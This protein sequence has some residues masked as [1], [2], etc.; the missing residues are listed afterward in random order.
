MKTPANVQSTAK[1]RGQRMI[2]SRFTPHARIAA[3]SLS[4]DMREKTRM[5]ATRSP[6]GIVHCIV[7]GKLTSAK[8]PTRSNGMPSRM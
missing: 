2:V 7:S 6:I 1:M 3:I 8:R 5:D 4:A